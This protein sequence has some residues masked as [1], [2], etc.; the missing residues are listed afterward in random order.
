MKIKD[1]DKVVY[2]GDTDNQTFYGLLFKKYKTYIV[3]GVITNGINS[4]IVIENI[5][6][7]YST[8]SFILLSEYRKLKLKKLCL[9]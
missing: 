3:R 4:A 7:Y 8:D 5:G 2:I 1:Y 9:E 6:G